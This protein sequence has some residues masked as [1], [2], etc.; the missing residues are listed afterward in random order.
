MIV[1]REL[2]ED[3][4]ATLT[5]EIDDPRH[6]IYGPGSVS[7]QLGGDIA[8]FIGGGRAALLQLAHPFVAYAI[9]EHS[10]TRSD[11]VGRFQR[12][13]R[14]VFAMTFGE[15]GAAVAAARRVHAVHGRIAG[16][17]PERVGSW[18]AGTPYAANDDAALR[19][20]H[21][22]LVDTVLVVRERLDGELPVAIKDKYVVEQNR[23]A[24]LFGLRDALLPRSWAEHAAYMERAIATLAVS[25]PAREMGAFLVGRGGVQ[26]PALG[27]IAES[28]TATLL[29]RH[30]VSAFGLAESP[31]T[32]AA[33]HAALAA[34]ARV[35]RRLPA[36]AVALPA[37]SE[38]VRR[39]AG[40]PRSALD[41]WSER[42]LF[43]LAQRT[44]GT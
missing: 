15:L 8:V 42:Q 19:W 41:A 3:S 28:I 33:V 11:V 14:N 26:Q 1:T 17:L 36:R 27:R 32:T 24:R 25:P 44:T 16:V 20:V 22:T 35:Y 40:K 5:R 18:A 21:A 12:T 4:L 29:P 2:L 39:I 34:F 37:R 13:F 7:W 10:R 9:A 43:A 6:G 23:F 38:A 30:L 31:R